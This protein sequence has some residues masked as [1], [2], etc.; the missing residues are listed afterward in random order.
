MPCLLLKAS[1]LA[2]YARSK[3]LKASVS[4]DNVDSKDVWRVIVKDAHKLRIAA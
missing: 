1:L 4:V 2:Q 3:G